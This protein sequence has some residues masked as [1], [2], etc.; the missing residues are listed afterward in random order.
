MES[1]IKALENTSV[2]ESFDEQLDNIISKLESSH[3][4]ESFEFEELSKNYSRLVYL[5]KLIR[6][7]NPD[8][9][10]FF[11]CLNLF[12]EEVDKKTQYYLKDIY[13]E[14]DQEVPIPVLQKIKKYLEESLN[15]NDPVIKLNLILSAYFI[16]VP[17]VENLNHQKIEIDV[18][19]DFKQQFKKRKLN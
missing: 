4:D 1:L 18:D 11:K 6:K 14:H 12:M 9:P 3:V 15:S 8:S 7:H 13:W 2:N 17:I 5:D 16:L 19:D 10:K